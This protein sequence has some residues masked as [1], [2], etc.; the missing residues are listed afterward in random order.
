MADST[1]TDSAGAT[2]HSRKF[3]WI[4]LGYWAVLFVATHVPL[5]GMNLQVSGGD[6]LLHF[7]F[8][9]VLALL[10]GRAALQRGQRLS[11]SWPLIWFGVYALYGAADELLQSL[12]R[13]TPSI[14]DWVADSS[15]A[16]AG[17]LVVYLNRRAFSSGTGEASD[18]LEVDP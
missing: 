4:W 18:D 11:R 3:T 5:G 9:F 6:K 15:G 16:L 17:L 12:A 8:F 14:G 13:R 2:G 10:G 1:P 7:V